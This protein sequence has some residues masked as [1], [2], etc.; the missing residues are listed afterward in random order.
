M[1]SFGESIPLGS[2]F[3]PVNFAHSSF[4]YAGETDSLFG[5]SRK[6]ASL[7]QRVEALCSHPVR[8]SL[9]LP[10]PHKI[11]ENK[12]RI[13]ISSHLTR[14]KQPLNAPQNIYDDPEFF[15]GYRKLRETGTGLNDVLEQPALWSLLP[16]SLQGLTILDLGCGFGTFARKARALGAASVLGVDV[17]EKMLELA[18]QLTKDDGIE[19]RRMGI[20]ELSLDG[21]NFDLIV[22][23][24]ALHYIPDYRTALRNIVS[25]L[26]PG[27]NFV[28]SVEHP[29]CTALPQQ[30]WVRDDKG[31]PLHW[32][33]DNYRMEGERHTTW[34]VEGVVKYHR[35]IE[36][37]VNGLIEAG[38]TIQ[39]L[40][41]PE[42]LVEA[43]VSIPDLE[44][45]RRR[46][47]FLVIG[48][49]RD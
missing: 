34:F 23:S 17:S 36:S 12:T 14:K 19:Y 49:K 42:P 6:D 38:L 39:R 33:V 13:Q 30:Q 40:L 16:S 46:P 28:F 45:Q 1:E 48:A 15:A 5:V 7:N 47:P 35:T 26:H 29:I 20:E 41:E 37:Y 44:H 18:G 10:A 21:R 8:A 32:P 27:G 2:F 24:L 11:I 31:E 43:L 3:V 4:F 22:S 25:V 9:Q